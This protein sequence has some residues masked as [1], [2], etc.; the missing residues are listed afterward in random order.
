[1]TWFSG[2]SLAL[3]LLFKIVN[4]LSWQHLTLMLLCRSLKRFDTGAI[5]P[6]SR[7]RLYGKTGYT[8]RATCRARAQFY[9][10]P[11]A[12]THRMAV[13]YRPSWR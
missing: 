11:A 5:A 7:W 2:S 8:D 13:L 4:G 9:F 3:L 12:E 1:M 6:V 10:E